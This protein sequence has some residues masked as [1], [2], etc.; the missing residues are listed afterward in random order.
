MG[1]PLFLSWLPWTWAVWAIRSARA[2]PAPFAPG[3]GVYPQ[4]LP[5]AGPHPARD[6][7]TQGRGFVYALSGAD[8]G[9]GPGQY[10]C[11]LVVG[12]ETQAPALG[13][14]TA[15]RNTAVIFA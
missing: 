6:V 2:T 9:I 3:S 12:A 10:R 8:A 5:G 14:S 15:G 7:R 13:V 4:P 1:T 11:V